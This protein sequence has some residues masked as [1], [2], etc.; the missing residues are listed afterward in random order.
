MWD[1]W[2]VFTKLITTMFS[3]VCP[4]PPPP[5]SLT[6]IPTPPLPLTISLYTPLSRT[7]H[8][9]CTLHVTESPPHLSLSHTHF[10]HI[11][12]LPSHTHTA[13]PRT[14]PS[15]SPP[16]HTLPPCSSPRHT[17]AFA[18]SRVITAAEKWSEYFPAWRQ[19]L[20]PF[21]SLFYSV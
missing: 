8:N 15:C 13:P 11:C 1:T 20:I 4:P 3:R 6:S 2:R 5:P 21:D 14:L 18:S 10:Y 19:R 17:R 7:T 16:P 9:F 12:F